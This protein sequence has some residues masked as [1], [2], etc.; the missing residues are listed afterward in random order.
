MLTA[1]LQNPK[2]DV[3]LQEDTGSMPGFLACLFG[4]GAQV[5]TS[6]FADNRPASSIVQADLTLEVSPSALWQHTTNNQESG[7]RGPP[8]FYNGSVWRLE[9]RLRRVPAAAGSGDGQGEE[10]PTYTIGLYLNHDMPNKPLAF[11]SNLVAVGT[12]AEGSIT[13]RAIELLICPSRSICGYHG[14]LPGR[15]TSLTDVI[16]DLSGSFIHSDGKLHFQA[17][18]TA[19]Y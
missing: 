14:M 3:L 17:T 18:I 11:N 5:R 13:K 7:L 4:P 15:F 2:A 8:A 6:W 9:G 19:V 1:M 10:A 12:A 16:N